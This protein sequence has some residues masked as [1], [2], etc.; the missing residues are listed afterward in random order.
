MRVKGDRTMFGTTIPLAE[1]YDYLQQKFKTGY[2][3][4]R[5]EG[6]EKMD[7]GTVRL[8]GGITAQIQ[9]YLT[10]KPKGAKFESHDRFFDIQYVVSG[11]EFFEVADRLPLPEDTPYDEEK[12]VTF[13]REPERKSRVYLGAGSLIVVSPE[14]VHRPRVS[15]SGPQT[16]KKIV[17]KIPV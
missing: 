17:I 7:P 14:E 2:E 1:K 5:R 10:G 16:V 4:L 13:Y 8:G 6:L 9:I 12:D 15:V 11:E 3:F